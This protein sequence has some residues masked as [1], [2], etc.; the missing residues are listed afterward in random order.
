MKSLCNMQRTTGTPQGGV[1]SP[2]LANLYLHYTLDSWINRINPSVQFVRYADDIIIHCKTQ[3]QAEQTLQNVKERV[4]ECC[5]RLHP[6]K[7]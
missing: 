1:I 2:L 5:L 4:R 6:E 7:T 3:G